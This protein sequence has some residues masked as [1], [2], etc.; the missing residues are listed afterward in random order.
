LSKGAGKT[1]EGIK[2]GAGQGS[3]ILFPA[4]LLKCEKDDREFLSLVR[5]GIVLLDKTKDEA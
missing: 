5:E 1:E 3:R 2:A 4:G